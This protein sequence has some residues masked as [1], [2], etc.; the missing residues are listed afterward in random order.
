M[1]WEALKR[2]VSEADAFKCPG[3]V[4]GG[5]TIGVVWGRPPVSPPP[6]MH[7]HVCGMGGPSNL[8]LARAVTDFHYPSQAMSTCDA[9][10][11]DSS[12]CTTVPPTHEGILFCRRCDNPRGPSAPDLTNHVPMERHHDKVNIGY[13]DA[14]AEVRPTEVLVPANLPAANTPE[15]DAFDRLWGH[16]LD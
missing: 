7:T 10:E 11:S 4:T 14:H 2:Y 16:K 13:V 1:W 9:E 15:G 5:R 3:A 8:P 6:D 12:T